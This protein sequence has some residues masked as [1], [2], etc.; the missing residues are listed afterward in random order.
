[1]KKAMWRIVALALAGL[2]TA[3][4]LWF[5][6]GRTPAIPGPNHIASLNASTSV[7]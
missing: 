3:L 5:T 2:G 6:P 7:M 1:M 4:Y